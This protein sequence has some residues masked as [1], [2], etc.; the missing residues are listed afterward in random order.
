[1]YGR[2]PI[3]YANGFKIIDGTVLHEGYFTALSFPV[4]T[5]IEE[6]E[7]KN[8]RNGTFTG[9]SLSVGAKTTIEGLFTKVKLQSGL[10]IGYKG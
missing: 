1:M 2:A 7:A 9:G 6:L 10:A 4:D 8:I 3:N 5:V